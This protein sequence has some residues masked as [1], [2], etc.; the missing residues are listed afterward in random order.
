MMTNISEK[1]KKRSYIKN[2]I[3][4]N[5]IHWKNKKNK[6]KSSGIILLEFNSMTSSH[7][8]YS[9]LANVLAKKN[10]WKIYGYISNGRTTLNERIKYKIKSIF[11]ISDWKIYKSFNTEKLIVP[12][13]TSKIRH[14]SYLELSKIKKSI[15]SKKDFE[16]LKCKNLKIGDLFYDSYLMESKQAT[17]DLKSKNFYNTISRYLLNFYFWIEYFKENKIKAVISSHSVYNLAV[18][19]RIAISKNILAFQANIHHTY[20]L[21]KKNIFGYKDFKYYRSKF[22]SFSTKEKSQAYKKAKEQIHKRFAGEVGVD[23]AYSSKSAFSNK[24]DESVIQ[25]TKNKKII[26]LSHCF[27]DSPHVY[28]NNLFPDFYEWLKFLG[29]CA[30][31]TRF[32]WYLKTHPDYLPGTLEILNEVLKKY[33][34]IKLLPPSTSHHSIIN[35]GIDVALTVYG[36][37][38]FEYPLL[39]VQVINA[40]K[41]NPHINY[42]FNFHPKNIKEYKKLILAKQNKLK[43]TKSSIYEFYYMN[44]IF[45]TC[46]IFFKQFY[47]LVE[48]IGYKNLFNPIVYK[49]WLD[50]FNEVHHENII[51]QLSVFIKVSKYRFNPAY[52]L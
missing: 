12:R 15:K 50:E 27:F 46:N 3:Y 31:T 4:H 33:P 11:P 21:N 28:G 1:I 32:D 23:M 29:A 36:T 51:N 19:L 20:K 18:P 44:N 17:I 25:K 10:N 7:I 49:M 48:K 16:N 2:F 39:G 34:R 6:N 45:F 37:V 13:I 52:D 40:S 30:E 14:E 42:K 5:T 38:G 41:N 47:R 9:Y 24:T 26:I 8:A 35:G 43:I 22:K